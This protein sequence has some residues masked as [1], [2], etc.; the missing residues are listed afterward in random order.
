MKRKKGSVLIFSLII[1]SLMLITALSIYFSSGKNRTSSLITNKS[2]QAFQAADSGAEIISRE[3]YKES[4]MRIE[5]LG[6]C[7][8]GG[9][10]TISDY[11]DSGNE[12]KYEVFFYDL[13]GNKLNC[14]SNVADIN[15][16][17]S[18][19]TYGGTVRAVNISVS[20]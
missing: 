7:D 14:S 16:L 10:E 6:D 9:A 15:G 20:P 19:G 2:N 17:H 12:R 13:N 8:S 5:D 18:V 11:I 1:L 3:I 4:N